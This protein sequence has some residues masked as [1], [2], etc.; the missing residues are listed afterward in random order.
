MQLIKYIKAV[1]Y[2]L[3]IRPVEK[4]FKIMP[5]ATPTPVSVVVA[6]VV[7]ATPEPTKRAT[8]HPQN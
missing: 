4:E 1:L 7:T 2:L 6:Q 3:E 5:T 8:K